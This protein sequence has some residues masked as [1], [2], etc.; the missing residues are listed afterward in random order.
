LDSEGVYHALDHWQSDAQDWELRQYDLSAYVG[1]TVTVYVGTRNDGDDDT[2]A[3][4]VD[5]VKVEVC[6]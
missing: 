3:L 1:Q 5:D 2:S 6:P 4:Y